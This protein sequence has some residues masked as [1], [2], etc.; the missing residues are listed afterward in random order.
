[1]FFLQVVYQCLTL[2]ESLHHFPGKS[3]KKSQK[4]T[5]SHKKSRTLSRTHI[6]YCPPTLMSLSKLVKSSPGGSHVKSLKGKIFQEK[7]PGKSYR[8]LTRPTPG[9]DFTS[10]ERLVLMFLT[11]LEIDGTLSTCKQ[12][13][14]TM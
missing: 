8:R 4:V 6:L 9:D 12:T 13:P 5:K 2:A 1:M 11:Y 3:H 14:F 7:N 10:L